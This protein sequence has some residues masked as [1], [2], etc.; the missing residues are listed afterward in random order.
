MTKRVLQVIERMASICKDRH[1]YLR[2]A[3]VCARAKSEGL[4][5]TETLT[6]LLFYP[7]QIASNIA[8]E[9]HTFLPLSLEGIASLLR[10]SL[11]TEEM[12][13]SPPNVPLPVQK[14]S[15]FSS[16]DITAP[17]QGTSSNNS[18]EGPTRLVDV[19][20]NTVKRHRRSSLDEVALLVLQ[21]LAE[22]IHNCAWVSGTRLLG[23]FQ[24]AFEAQLEVRLL[25]ESG[26]SNSILPHMLT[27]IL[28]RR[29]T[30]VPSSQ[31]VSQQEADSTSD[32]VTRSNNA[33]IAEATASSTS[34]INRVASTVPPTG[35]GEPKKTLSLSQYEQDCYN[36]LLRICD[37]S[38]KPI[39][40][41][42]P[43]GSLEWRSKVLS[44]AL[45]AQFIKEINAEFV[46][47]DLFMIAL[48]ENVT[49]SLLR[50]CTLEDA[51]L[52][53]VPLKTL[54]HL[55]VHYREFLKSKVVVIF[56]GVLIPLVGSKSTSYNQKYAILS[57]FELT[58]RKHHVV[59]DWFTNLDCVQGMPSFCEVLVLRLSKL[60][61]MSHIS[62][63]VTTKEDGTLR[64]K[65]IKALCAYIQSVELIAR[66]FH[67]CGGI[68]ATHVLDRQAAKNRGEGEAT[69][70]TSEVKTAGGGGDSDND[71]K[72]GD[73][74]YDDAE[75]EA[76]ASV[77][78]EQSRSTVD[79]VRLADSGV[80]QLLR[81]KKA[82][83]SVV[84]VFNAGDYAT[85]LKMALNVGIL[86][87]REPETVA[88][89][90]LQRKLDPVRVGE[91]LCKND[92]ERKTI[93]RAFISLNDFADLAIDE[94]MRVFLGK[95]KLPGEAQVV[96]RT[97]EI[98]AEQYCVQNPTIFSGPSPAFILAFSI[99]MLNTDAHST[100][101]K[102]KMTVEQFIQNNRGIDDGKDLPH[103]FLRDIY[104][105]IT[106]NGIILECREAVQRVGSAMKPSNT[107]DSNLLL[108][109]TSSLIRGNKQRLAR[110]ME[111]ECLVEIT[112]DQI[113]QDVRAEPYT[114]VNSPEV[115]R[116]MLE[117]TWTA[118]LAAFA[119]PMEEID[120]MEFIDT[121][122]DGF[123]SAIKV[124]CKFSCRTER[125]A[126][127]SAIL[128]FT[129]LTN[130]REIEYKS[131]KSIVVLIRIALE[132]GDHL[133][134]SWY[135]I[136]RCISLLAKLHILA[137]SSPTMPPSSR[138]QGFSMM[139]TASYVGG[140]VDSR[141]NTQLLRERTKFE[142]QNAETIAKYIDEVEAHRLFSRSNHLKDASVVDLVEAICVVSAEELAENP[143]R[144][145]SLQKL[146]EVTD[147]NIWR[148]RY[149]W[150][151]MWTN[152]SRHFVTIGLS[153]N[154]LVSMFVVDHL[155]QLATKFLSRKELGNFNFQ[156]DVLRPF[157]IIASQAKSLALKELIIAS[158]GQM[159]EAQA[160][161]LGSGWSALLA[162]LA[163]CVRDVKSPEAVYSAAMVLQRITLFHLHFL[164]S[165]DL[166]DVINAWTVVGRSTPGGVTAQSAVWYIRYV[167]AV[168]PF[169][170]TTT[171]ITCA[172][173]LNTDSSDLPKEPCGRCASRFE[174]STTNGDNHVETQRG[175]SD[176][177]NN[178]SNE[179][180][181]IL[182]MEEI[183]HRT[184]FFIHS[185]LNERD[186]H[187]GGG[188]KEL[189]TPK[190]TTMSTLCTVATAALT[191]LVVADPISGDAI[192]VMF[193]I[194]SDMHSAFTPEAWWCAFARAVAP[195]LDYLLLRCKSSKGSTELCLP[196][197][198][199][200]VTGVVH[201]AGSILDAAPLRVEDVRFLFQTIVGD[202]CTNENDGVIE[203]GFQGGRQLLQHL[204]ERAV[205]DE[206]L[207]S[208]V[209]TYM[210]EVG[211]DLM[212]MLESVCS[213]PPVLNQR[214]AT[215]PCLL[216][217]LQYVKWLRDASLL[218]L[219]TVACRAKAVD[220]LVCILHRT[221][222]LLSTSFFGRLDTTQKRGAYK[223]ALFITL[224]RSVCNAI[225]QVAE[226]YTASMEEQYNMFW[227]LVMK[228]FTTIS[229][230]ASE[231][232]KQEAVSLRELVRRLL[233]A[234]LQ[235]PSNV[236]VERVRVCMPFLCK[237]I[238]VN[239]AACAASL[240]S[241]FL[242][243]HTAITDAS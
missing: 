213:L 216:A 178:N 140:D 49:V 165:T 186:N 63:W 34:Y 172:T 145:F 80:E 200:T 23:C 228:Q 238:A 81:D 219:L 221:M 134:D 39:D 163:H 142:R 133:E 176:N 32:C 108:S 77:Y 54:Y 96:D 155:R 78:E 93:L 22:I 21:C 227:M 161:S 137:D 171:A 61:K 66:G 169:V 226:R 147:T 152:V 175:D 220:A 101:I 65:C 158:L 236:M 192:D 98:F 20:L 53:G 97:M 36:I 211:E 88:R 195:I 130:Y 29:T 19:I 242:K 79:S 86:S 43:V 194:M 117:S 122:L 153:A 125:R 106:T 59:R 15:L 103:Q 217:L 2:A 157:E 47:S 94:A 191:S 70:A 203:I 129:H 243:Y 99:M 234:M 168:S 71:A 141:S 162:A 11:L 33:S 55:V 218:P 3:C 224:E 118:L 209:V 105:R 40:V 123:E 14:K 184:S 204:D 5:N 182:L 166:V 126:F 109:S 215:A 69:C 62:R 24:F 136:L 112:L 235:A 188:L 193:A 76:A 237:M 26:V 170:T 51:V 104:Q 8:N 85:A 143:P 73:D 197:L 206:A 230:G 124:C 25:S 205:D 127:I 1:A 239:D 18:S 31:Q 72:D 50:N 201:L 240:A 74:D 107:K 84:E 225:L 7:L 111:K 179:N 207:W 150:S 89:F 13:Y 42:A 30:P 35:G 181:R 48:H 183:K 87:S 232:N 28:A 196:L 114:S 75:N 95:F 67:A 159:V 121:C 82:Y 44:C 149:I 167:V 151:K 164:T 214:D 173:V 52:Y 156:K 229:L 190:R 210:C 233:D 202:L 37:L 223:V 187:D 113:T 231:V 198:K 56:L 241:L 38:M 160:E 138:N 189:S 100:H 58:L 10:L 199:Q 64:L 116:A 4:S 110:H 135:E 148:Q 180:N 132:E 92:D 91:Y 128:A 174:A 90:L 212:G 120:N 102:E 208:C 131:L 139:K 68:D 222:S 9:Q 6:N 12:M 27:A 154:Q 17:A 45:L 185:T 115:A 46:Q 177:N 57:F 146:V 119:I 41:S 16:T 60:V 144:L 83:D